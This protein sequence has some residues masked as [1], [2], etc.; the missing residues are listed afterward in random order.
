MTMSDVDL[1][2]TAARKVRS[3]AAGATPGPWTNSPVDDNRY[4]ALVSQTMPEGRRANGGW[5]WEASYGGCLVGESIMR[6]DR[7]W[8][9]LADPLFGA[10]VAEVLDEAADE[11]AHATPPGAALALARLV[12]AVPDVAA[13]AN[14]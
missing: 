5:E 12:M 6:Q 2:R 14:Q 11:F 10:A 8:I 13:A 7:R 1:L 9:A 4:S 3:L